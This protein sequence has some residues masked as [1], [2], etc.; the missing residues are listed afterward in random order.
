MLVH[1]N[2]WQPAVCRSQANAR[3]TVTHQHVHWLMV[4]CQR[5]HDSKLLAGCV[6]TCISPTLAQQP[7]VYPPCV[8]HQ[9][10]VGVGVASDVG[11]PLDGVAV[12]VPRQDATSNSVA[13]PGEFSSPFCP[14][15]YRK[16]DTGPDNNRSPMCVF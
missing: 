3:G 11:C 14:A 7:A 10:G 12:D 9:V 15:L 4:D 8:V 16:E 1:T 13:A 2:I 5:H 6:D